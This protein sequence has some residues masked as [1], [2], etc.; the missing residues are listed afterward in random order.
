M[1]DGPLLRIEDLTVAFGAVTA[2]DA[3]GF[4]VP[5][6]GTIGL[7][8]PNGAGKTTLLNAISGFVRAAGSIA[9]DGREL[10]DRSPVARARLGI[11]RTFQQPRM[12][13]DQTLLDH[14]RVAADHAPGDALAPA[15]AVEAVGLA[16]PLDAPCRELSAHE[17]TL[18]EIARAL[19]QRPRLLLLD[20][21]AAGLVPTEVAELRVAI[22]RLTAELELAVLLIDH[23]MDLVLQASDTVHVLDFG[24]RIFA[25][26]PEEV[27]SSQ[28]VIDAYL[29]TDW[30]AA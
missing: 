1:A 21:P 5:A 10:L 29:G 28:L 4:D 17:Q 3:V 9:F 6:R 12:F 11:A 26:T 18:A 13:G 2:V 16:A 23:D 24:K 20:E 25:G 19:V 14:L 8:G 15:G 7:I 27:R 22:G 30:E